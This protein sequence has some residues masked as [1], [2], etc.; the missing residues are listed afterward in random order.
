[1]TLRN[2]DRLPQEV[3]SL[4]QSHVLILTEALE[5]KMTGVYVHG[6]AAMGGFNFTQSD[7]DYLA[8]V[9]VPLDAGER[10]KLADSFLKV[11]GKGA[12]AKGVEMSIVVE[13]FV[14]K[15][16]RYPP[17]Y[18]FHMGTEEQVKLHGCPH[19]HEM[20]DPDLAAHFTVIKERGVCVYGKVID[21]VFAEVPKQYYLAAIASDS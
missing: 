10:K 21:E 9:S 8:V 2:L 7:L 19:M 13:E 17:P 1:M 3:I 5:D 20:L 12:P 4:L 18:E 15:G 6:S 14:G 11:Y 16:F